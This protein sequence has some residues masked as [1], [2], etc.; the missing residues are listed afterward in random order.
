[1]N[2]THD[3][4][5]DKLRVQLT[6]EETA[7]L[8]SGGAI[9]TNDVWIKGTVGIKVSGPAIAA[10]KRLAAIFEALVREREWQDDKYGPVIMRNANGED[11]YDHNTPLQG[12]GG[13]ELGT[14]LIILEKELEEAKVAAVHGG[15][16]A[17]SGRN[18]IRQ[19]LVQVAAVCV[20]ALEQHGLEE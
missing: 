5:T 2:I 6:A 16:K 7:I 10:G 19:E 8:A 14:W 1:M 12:K 17:T 13:H 20:A 3:H 15:S 18:S 9:N 4:S 11:M